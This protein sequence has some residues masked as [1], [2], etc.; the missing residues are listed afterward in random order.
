MKHGDKTNKQ[1][2]K[3]ICYLFGVIIAAANKVQNLVTKNLFL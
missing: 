1:V 3:Y 2:I